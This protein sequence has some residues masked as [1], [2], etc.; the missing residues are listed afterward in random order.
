VHRSI[1]HHSSLFGF[2]E[3]NFLVWLFSTSIHLSS[4]LE[5]FNVK[6][7]SKAL[8]QIRKQVREREREKRIWKKSNAL[9]NQLT[10]S[11]PFLQ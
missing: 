8:K 5:L 10:H 2:A 11:N 7:V 1:P 4:L 3:A 9:I 6:N